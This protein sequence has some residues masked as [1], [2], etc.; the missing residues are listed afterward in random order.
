[1]KTRIVLVYLILTAA[2]LAACVEPGTGAAN[3]PTPGVTSSPTGDV[4]KKIADSARPSRR[5]GA[6]GRPG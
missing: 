2:L 3:T 6:P 4:R 1:M 5:P